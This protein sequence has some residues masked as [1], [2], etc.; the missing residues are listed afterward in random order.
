MIDIELCSKI[1]YEKKI[2][3]FNSNEFTNEI[4]RITKKKNTTQQ[5]L[6]GEVEEKTGFSESKV[7]KWKSGSTELK[8]WDDLV[9]FCKST[10]AKM[11][12]IM[13]FN[14]KDKIFDTYIQAREISKN[15]LVSDDDEY[16]GKLKSLCDFFKY[17]DEHLKNLNIQFEKVEKNINRLYQDSYNKLNE[18]IQRK[19]E[20]EAKEME[21]KIKD[22]QKKRMELEKNYKDNFNKYSFL[23]KGK[24]KF[25]YLL[26]CY[27]SYICSVILLGS[28]Y[29]K[30]NVGFFVVV[31]I[32]TLIFM[33]FR[34]FFKIKVKNEYY[35]NYE[36]RDNEFMVCFLIIPTIT[37]LLMFTNFFNNTVSIYYNPFIN[38]VFVSVSILEEIGFLKN[39][40]YIT[41]KRKIG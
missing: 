15:N 4:K 18:K 14:F 5:K 6:F 20:E 13:V 24:I 27:F 33:F 25:T 37:L 34:L 35:H 26:P 21:Q 41:A 23:G 2:I 40:E 16:C 12:N 9:K 31:L 38:A 28:P 39:I 3:E 22:E 36:K 30:F 29:D 8:K 1:N 11:E 10:D 17:S 7:K 32:L 19:K